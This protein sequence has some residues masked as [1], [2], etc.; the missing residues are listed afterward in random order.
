VVGVSYSDSKSVS[1][2]SSQMGLG[3]NNIT[4]CFNFNVSEFGL[5][6]LLRR[7]GFWI[8]SRSFGIGLVKL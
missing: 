5:C 2:G 8:V 4:P 6:D 1:I 3:I 7:F